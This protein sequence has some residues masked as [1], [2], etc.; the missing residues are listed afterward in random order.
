MLVQATN[1]LRQASARSRSKHLFDR[2]KGVFTDGTTRASVE[3]DPFP[4]YAQRGE[5]AY[6]VDVDGNRLLD[7]NNNFTTLIHGHGF[8]HVSEAVVDLLRLGTC[9]ANPTEHEIALAELL[10]A[11]I[12]A[13]ER[14]RFVNSGTE[15]VMF[16]IKAARAFTARPAIARIEGA[17]HGAYDWAEA[18]QGVS[19]GKDGWDPIPIP[20]PTYRGTPSSVA[21]EVHLLR[22]NDV[23]GLERRLSAAS[24]RIACVL[25]DPMPSRAGL[26]PP[27]PTFIEALSETAHKYGILIV[28]DEVLNLRQGYAGASPR[29]GLKPDL[30]TAGKIIGGGFPIGAIGG[31]EEVMRV[32]GT[33]NAQPLLP[34][35]GTFSA[36]P[37][38]MAAGLAAMEAMTPDA[39]DRLEA[40]GERLR[41]GLRASIAS[42][43]ARF[44]VTGAASLFRIH[45]KR[46]APLEYR[47]AHLS[48][49]EAWIMRTMSRSFLEAGIL[50]P[51]GAAAC[52]STPMVHSDIDRIL[53]AFDEFLEAKIGPG[54]ERA[55]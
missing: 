42:R 20:T 17:Y 40:M 21:D 50:L 3:R 43:D 41:A 48:A 1:R 7:L 6:L 49:E 52:L 10:T 45:P 47:D 38:S 26:L 28:A 31:R 27:E 15:A 33:E 11:R 44:S 46:V 13:M 25:I 5:G 22:F 4:I 23:E 55:K 34:Q 51:Y 54:K 30:V 12:P 16:A 35:G 2:A 24:D 9:F 39:F 8:A 53:S 36:N 14:V 37:V 32:F 18:G 29:Y 19:P